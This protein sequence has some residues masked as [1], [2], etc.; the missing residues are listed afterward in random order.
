M[1]PNSG[2]RP[3]RLTSPM[4]DSGFM[5]FEMGQSDFPQARGDVTPAFNLWTSWFWN[6][7][8]KLNCGR[9]DSWRLNL[10]ATWRLNPELGKA[11][12]NRLADRLQGTQPAA[13]PY[14]FIAQKYYIKSFNWHR[15]KKYTH[16]IKSLK[17]KYIITIQ[18]I[19]QIM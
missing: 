1:T 10:T 4:F 18:Q 2:Q 5:K 3:Y 11:Y 15:H 16:W 14:I 17:C 9:N 6:R 7:M 13:R 8:D 19:Q 12:N